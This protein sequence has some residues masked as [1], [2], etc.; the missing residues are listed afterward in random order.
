MH[1]RSIDLR[2]RDREMVTTI[3]AAGRIAT[4]PDVKLIMF[5]LLVGFDSAWTAEKSGAIV[6]VLR[7]SGRNL[8]DRKI[9]F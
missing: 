3:K 5:T 2:C 7:A 6:G 8:V 1:G 9:F 4:S